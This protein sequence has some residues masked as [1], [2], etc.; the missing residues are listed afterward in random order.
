MPDAI[1]AAAIEIV[2]DTA[3]FLPR[4]QAQISTALAKVKSD[5]TIEA[6]IVSPTAAVG[7]QTT[8]AATGFAALEQ[9]VQ[10]AKNAAKDAT[11][12]FAEQKAAMHGVAVGT[13]EQ[14]AALAQLRKANVEY[15]AVLKG[16]VGLED[17][18]AIAKLRETRATEAAAAASEALRTVT[19]GTSAAM[20][21]E[22]ETA[23]GLTGALDALAASQAAQTDASIAQKVAGSDFSKSI[24]S[25]TL[26]LTGFSGELTAV[27]IAGFVLFQS[28]QQRSA[29]A[30]NMRTIQV[31][32]H[33]T[34]AEMKQ[35]EQ[36][37]FDLSRALD[38]PGAS[39]S[40]AVDAMAELTHKGFDL[41]QSQKLA[42]TVLLESAAAAEDVGAAVDQVTNL[43]LGYHIAIKDATNAT[44][45]LTAAEVAGVG[46]TDEV[47][48]ALSD[49]AAGARPLGL[50]IR[51]VST[52]L[53]QLG[54]DGISAGD[55]T[56]QLQAIFNA[57]N[58]DSKPFREALAEIHVKMGDLVDDQGK[59]KPDAFVIL[60]KGVEDF[61]KRQDEAGTSTKQ[62]AVEV[63]R[64]ETQLFSFRGFR[65]G[66]DLIG[67][68][69]EGFTV[70]AERANEFGA[71]AAEAKK[72]SEDLGGQIRELQDNVS[73]LGLV[74]GQV[75]E[76][77]A[78]ILVGALNILT[79]SLED[80]VLAADGAIKEGIKLAREIVKLADFAKTPINFVIH[81]VSDIAGGVH[82]FL[83]KIPGEKEAEKH[84]RE[85]AHGLEVGLAVTSPIGP[86]EETI[87]KELAN[88]RDKSKAVTDDMEKQT[89]ENLD[90]LAED[91]RDAGD[92][93]A[94]RQDELVK[95]TQEAA[96][97]LNLSEKL[98][99][100]QAEQAPL[101][102]QLAAAQAEQAAAARHLRREQRIGTHSA[103]AN[104][105][106]ALKQANSDVASITGEMQSNADKAASDAKSKA[107]KIQAAIAKQTD[108]LLGAI[109]SEQARREA[110]FQRAST[111]GNLIEEIKADDAL[112]NFFR[113]AI[114][115]IR[116]RIKDVREAGG[117]TGTLKAA[118][119][120]Y[121]IAKQQVRDELAG[122]KQDQR[123]EAEEIASINEQILEARFGSDPT[124]GQKSKLIAAHEK[125]IETLKLE[126][127]HTRRRSVEYKRL[128]LQIEQEKAAIRDLRH[129]MKDSQDTANFGALAFQFLQQQQGILANFGSNF[130]PEGALTVGGSTNRG[131]RI[132]PGN[133]GTKLPPGMSP[134]APRTSTT[135]QDAMRS[136]G[137]T[138]GQAN[139]LIHNMR[140]LVREVHL[141]RQGA[142]HPR[143]RHQQ[144]HNDAAHDH[145][146]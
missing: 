133:I 97:K 101:Q 30:D 103:V 98:L 8:A 90:R 41:A 106:A 29:F 9:S 111:A 15:Q 69:P 116:A 104:A 91:W 10:A 72:Q 113:R 58:K 123:K 4:A 23:V 80:V 139:E 6:N 105:A 94:A 89:K 38:V 3:A 60:S 28:L 24:G 144:A 129:S 11:T 145:K 48:Q 64:L 136:V 73:D 68:G 85:I 122:L 112:R 63:R 142:G 88:T 96:R 109:S 55:A 66:A 71:T 132:Q 92:A 108:A 62:T 75:T 35:T 131:N 143:N 40:E 43:V 5:L 37:A 99:V 70:A 25:Q 127:A 21:G 146:N 47:A 76:P 7:A 45:A 53:I 134:F 114:A 83:N 74:I 128:Q 126:Q 19:K 119:Q 32:T 13:Q 16:Q 14:E 20:A 51:D 120:A 67:Q 2:P 118:L 110:R 59:L 44:D 36:I 22:I 82:D 65:G 79:K 18:D 130:F 77:A 42:K 115:D 87:V 135:D 46:S 17:A 84:G 52:F 107:S 61:R 1:G 31:A 34:G 26:A 33:A 140:A 27:A 137:I 141:L 39:A 81:I 86:L 117:D 93:I 57:I 12:T 95:H 78:M 49:L 50:G 100:L 124:A 121:R 125:I 138:H 56:A 102:V 54:N